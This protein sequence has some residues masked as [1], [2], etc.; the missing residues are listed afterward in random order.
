LS[1]HDAAVAT[2]A[3]EATREEL[4]HLERQR[5]DFVALLE[6][7]LEDTIDVDKIEHV[8]EEDR[9]H[10]KSKATVRLEAAVCKMA[11]A[12]RRRAQ[13][14]A[15]AFAPQNTIVLS[16]KKTRIRAAMVRYSKRIEAQRM[17]AQGLTLESDAAASDAAA[18]A[19]FDAAVEPA[20]LDAET[21]LD[22]GKAAA[23]DAD[24]L[25]RSGA[26]DDGAWAGAFAAHPA[27][28]ELGSE[29]E[30]FDFG[31]KLGSDWFGRA[32]FPWFLRQEA[33]F[34]DE[35]WTLAKVEA[36]VEGSALKDVRD[37]A[38]W[39]QSAFE[40][41]EA[42]RGLWDS[43][44]VRWTAN[45]GPKKYCGQRSIF[46]HLK[47]W[48]RQVSDELR[49]RNW[50]IE[51]VRATLAETTLAAFDDAL[52]ANA[53]KEAVMQAWLKAVK[54]VPAHSVHSQT[55]PGQ[56]ASARFLPAAS[57][58]ASSSAS[59]RAPGSGARERAQVG[60]TLGAFL[61]LE[62]SPQGALRTDAETEQCIEE[63]TQGLAERN[64]DV[65]LARALL[66]GPPLQVFQKAVDQWAEPSPVEVR[67][68]WTEAV[69]TIASGASAGGVDGAA[70]S[71]GAVDGA[72]SASSQASAEAKSTCNSIG[73]AT[74][75]EAAAATAHAER[76]MQHDEGLAPSTELCSRPTLCAAT[77]ATVAPTTSDAGRR[78]GALPTGDAPAVASTTDAAVAVAPSTTAAAASTSQREVN[79]DD[80]A[81]FQ[82]ALVAAV[83]RGA[84]RGGQAALAAPILARR[85]SSS[86]FEAEAQRRSDA[87]NAAALDAAREAKGVA[88]LVRQ[89]V[90]GGKK[91]GLSELEQCDVD[92]VAAVLACYREGRWQ[93]MSTTSDVEVENAATL[94]EVSRVRE[95]GGR[96]A[97]APAEPCQVDDGPEE[98]VLLSV[99]AAT[100]VNELQA[101]A[102]LVRKALLDV[103]MHWTCPTLRTEDFV[104][105]SILKT[106]RLIRQYHALR[107][108]VISLG[109]WAASVLKGG[110]VVATRPHLEMWPLHERVQILELQLEHSAASLAALDH[111]KATLQAEV[112]RLKRGPAA[113]PG[114]RGSG[115][116][117][118]ARGSGASLGST[119]SLTAPARDG[120]AADSAVLAA[121]LNGVR[122]TMVLRLH[123]ALHALHACTASASVR[124]EET[125]ALSVEACSH[126]QTLKLQVASDAPPVLHAIDALAKTVAAS[127]S[128]N[129][130]H[131]NASLVAREMKHEHAL[132][133]SRQQLARLVEEQGAG[134]PQ[135]LRAEGVRSAE[136]Q[137]RLELSAAQGMLSEAQG[138]IEER[139]AAYL[140]LEGTVQTLISQ[141]HLLDGERSELVEAQA[142]M[143]YELQAMEA[144]LAAL[145]SV[146]LSPVRARDDG[147]GGASPMDPFE[148][149]P[150]QRQFSDED[151]LSD[152]D[153]HDSHHDSPSFEDYA[154]EDPSSYLARKQ[155][156][157]EHRAAL[158]HL[159]S[160]L[161]RIKA[162]DSAS[163]DVR[164][165]ILD[166]YCWTHHDPQVVFNGIPYESIVEEERLLGKVGLQLA[167]WKKSTRQTCRQSK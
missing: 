41:A 114:A 23:G 30:A 115:A 67:A 103:L 101:Q 6:D 111:A 2:G 121:T 88:A 5:D 95:D 35:G 16:A 9:N 53:S 120:D 82:R 55:W 57:K 70:A 26:L 117:P 38:E 12:D 105:H 59:R 51:A 63:T 40:C 109:G 15:V 75:L 106:R 161:S 33:V 151:S 65:G 13:F 119:A 122:R 46:A 85:S 97:W 76:P 138:M 81:A 84:A 141:A 49:L 66:S 62:P 147:S 29:D 25:A 100:P 34:E 163:A 116:L 24:D 44:K 133:V 14:V 83:A 127:I 112:R 52:P 154:E 43:L 4:H 148:K 107:S 125:L 91:T 45:Y 39:L 37:H 72:A 60:H 155:L 74:A 123:R 167:S 77:A 144:Q 42:V 86:I 131:V 78:A 153:S 126:V 156:K 22:P 99:L 149:S 98:V 8:L 73:A 50:A 113:L 118:G 134:C 11:R 165:K 152:E 124:M 18:D 158:K 61:G 108:A 130:E 93:S 10:R 56:R 137:L 69:G 79:R 146:V 157:Q 143:V 166:A 20:T 102:A 17:R 164:L 150:M 3:A 54:A 96:D 71:A 47:R 68:A 162:I 1:A 136:A 159:Q 92:R 87:F 31:R 90:Q 129:A 160:I 128:A 145:S 80:P 135:C 7:V 94:A 104:P 89:C 36:A 140:A 32:I 48:V 142:R 139:E 19:A 64:W 27:G 21:A 58:R 110:A 28:E 132:K